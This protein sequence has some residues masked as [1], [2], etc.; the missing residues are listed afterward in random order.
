VS[1]IRAMLDGAPDWVNV[2]SDAPG[3]LLP[4]D[5]RP[6]PP[7]FPYEEGGIINCNG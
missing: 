4:G 7:D 6:D 1:W 5:P 3:T 2:D